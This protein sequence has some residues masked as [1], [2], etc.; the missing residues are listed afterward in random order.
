MSNGNTA[1]DG[2]SGRANTSL[3]AAIDE[4]VGVHCHIHSGDNFLDIFLAMFIMAHL[5]IVVFR[6]HFNPAIFALHPFRFTI[7]PL[8]LLASMGLSTWALIIGSVLTTFWD[9]YHSSLQT[10][11]LGRIYDKL[12]GNDPRVGRRLD[13]ILNFVI[14]AGPIAAG[15]TLMD[16]V[17]EFSDF[18]LV[19]AVFFTKIPAYVE[20][21]SG[22]LSW[23]VI[24]TGVPFL[25]Y[26][27]FAYWR[28]AR[29]GHRISYQKVALLFCTA[30]CSIYA[31][32]F[33]PFGMA[34]FIVNFFHALQYFGIIWWAERK[35]LVRLAGGEGLRHASAAA[36]VLLIGFALVYGFLAGNYH[37]HNSWLVATFLT[38]SL[39]HFW[40][41]GFIWS[42][43]RSQI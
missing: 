20:S 29:A 32:G 18:E 24:G 36:L 15:A 25:A 16:H 38:V 5:V 31:W 42:T 1:I 17:N 37:G 23:L 6:S 7:V 19:H 12:A 27:L 11:G 41:D 13:I 3:G 2:L 28:L 43:R 9:V 33:N 39:M 4:A 30:V 26:Y 40:Y 35:T 34:F 8:L 10:F 22:I 14:Y 21:N